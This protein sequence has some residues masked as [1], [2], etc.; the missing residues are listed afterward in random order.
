[1][2]S[3]SLFQGYR[4]LPGLPCCPGF[5]SSSSFS[6]PPLL[7]VADTHQPSPACLC[8]VPSSRCPGSSIT[9]TPASN[10]VY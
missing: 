1:M 9:G 7:L 3:S 8:P 10:I 2:L 6:A 5:R 4:C